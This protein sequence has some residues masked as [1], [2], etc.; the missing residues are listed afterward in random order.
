MNIINSSESTRYSA[1]SG[2]DISTYL[3]LQP[4]S[5][6]Y[7][8]HFTEPTIH[9]LQVKPFHLIEIKDE[10]VQLKSFLFLF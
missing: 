2:Y 3:K 4:F 7:G 1:S 6:G 9:T 5:T 8:K 10:F